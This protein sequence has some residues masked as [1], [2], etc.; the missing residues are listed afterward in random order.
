MN[1]K[2]VCMKRKVSDFDCGGMQTLISQCEACFENTTKEEVK[3]FL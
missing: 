1:L 3:T 2:Q